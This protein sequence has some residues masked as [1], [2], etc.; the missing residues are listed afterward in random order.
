MFIIPWEHS[1]AARQSQDAVPRFSRVG[2]PGHSQRLG[3]S[4]CDTLGLG[5]VR[6][7]TKVCVV[8]SLSFLGASLP[9]W[10]G[11]HR[12]PLPG[13]AP[14]SHSGTGRGHSCCV[15]RVVSRLLRE[16]CIRRVGLAGVFPSRDDSL[17]CMRGPLPGTKL[18][19]I[20]ERID[21]AC[22]KLGSA[23]RWEGQ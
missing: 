12:A 21:A 9:G 18:S 8:T 10:R 19:E 3:V 22:R 5:H 20:R 2:V 17:S 6:R 1:R 11:W 7:M 23:G 13:T 16:S 15:T 4:L 14:V